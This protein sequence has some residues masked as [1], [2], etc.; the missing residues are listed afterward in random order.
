MFM[1]N[2]ITIFESIDEISEL[3]KYGFY[4]LLSS[5]RIAYLIKK[6]SSNKSLIRGGKPIDYE[7]EY[8]DAMNYI[9][10]MK[11][12]IQKGGYKKKNR[13]TRKKYNKNKKTRKYFSM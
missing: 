2:F 3:I 8:L 11:N 5:V 9:D 7:N 13:I 4:Q 6:K 12:I 1:K 10:N